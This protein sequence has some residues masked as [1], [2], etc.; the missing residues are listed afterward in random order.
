MRTLKRVLDSTE[1]PDF[2]PW[3]RVNHGVEDYSLGIRF[4]PHTGATGTYSIEGCLSNPEEFV[5]AQFTRS[6]TTLT[7]NFIDEDHGLIAGDG[8]QFQ[9]SDWDRTDGKSYPLAGITDADTITVTVANSGATSGTIMVAKYR[10]EALDGLDTVS[11]RQSA[12][13]TGGM[14]MIR[15][16][17]DG[18]S[19]SGKGTLEVTQSNS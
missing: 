12:S 7:I 16:N 6:T 11:G 14:Q 1:S 17:V 4:N 9:G 10:I 19:F 18:G 5:K 13:T 3:I 8:V 2:S 15:A